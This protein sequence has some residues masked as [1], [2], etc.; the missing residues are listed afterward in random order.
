MFCR[1]AIGTPAEVQWETVGRVVWLCAL[2]AA[3][4][5]NTLPPGHPDAPGQPPVG[6][7]DGTKSSTEECD[8]SDLGGAT[9]ADAVAP[10]WIGTLACSATCTFD[11]AACNTP[12]TTFTASYNDSANWAAFDSTTVNANAKGFASSVFDGRY[13][14]FVANA[15]SMLTRYDTQAA[16]ATA[17]SWST[18]DLSALGPTVTD[19]QGG[20]FDGR[21]VY[22]VP[23]DGGL[24]GLVARFDSQNPSG[25]TS[26][27]SWTTFD[28]TTVNPAAH[29]FVRSAFDGRY[30]Y[31]SPY[32]NG[33]IYHGVTAR[34]DTQ[35]TAGFTSATS[36]ETVDLTT[37]TAGAA[38]FLGIVFDG[39]YLYYVP[40]ANATSSWDG[41]VMRFDPQSAAGFADKSSWTSFSTATV[42]GHDVGYYGGIFD[43]RYLYFP[44][45]YDGSVPA[46]GSYVI[47]YDTQAAFTSTASWT[48]YSPAG[49]AGYTGA[50]YDG[51]FVY[52][53]GYYNGTAYTGLST[54]YDTTA[55]FATAGSWSSFDASTVNAGAKGFDGAAC[56]GQYVYMVPD[57]N[58][59]GVVDGIV[60]R[61]DAKSA[62][63][64]PRHWN[65]NF[66]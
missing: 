26:A 24:S 5:G 29:G 25:F 36:W 33:T 37:I 27:D 38:G 50:T 63:W 2:V 17:A 61:F 15:T 12:A 8:G 46:Y 31:F 62:S 51:R 3:C 1:L 30:I 41:I 54:R 16:F 20:A 4:S 44:Q 55:D 64:L 34:F 45:H 22:L 53:S 43:G 9:C 10:G 48:Q 49:V 52:F 66:D 19:F 7:G 58:A 57:S 23:Y 59:A 13:L 21:Y 35:N 60:V 42:L 39:R 40:Y 14:Y 56:D 32:N 47:R 65:G 11:I 18:F 28:I 6:C